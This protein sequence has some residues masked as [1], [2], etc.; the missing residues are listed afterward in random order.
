MLF[1]SSDGLSP[2]SPIDGYCHVTQNLEGWP[3]PSLGDECQGSINI[4][5]LKK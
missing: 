5:P 3:G 2:V 1:L 4:F